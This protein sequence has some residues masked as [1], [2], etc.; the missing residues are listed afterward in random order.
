MTYLDSIRKKNIIHE[1]SISP[2][3]KVNGDKGGHLV[4]RGTILNWSDNVG[5]LCFS[6]QKQH[7]YSS[8]NTSYV[9]SG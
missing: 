5:S 9:W 8:K 4:S 6:C 2:A 1:Y 3:S 7:V